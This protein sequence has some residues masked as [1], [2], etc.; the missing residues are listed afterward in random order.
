VVTRWSRVGL[1]RSCSTLSP[2]SRGMGDCLRAR[3]L[4]H[5][6]TSHPG[7]FSLHGNHSIHGTMSTG[8]GYDHRWEGK[9]RVL[10]S[11]SPCDQDCWYNLV[12]Q[13]IKGAGWIKLS[14]PSGWSGPY[15]G[16]IGFNRRRLKWLRGD[17]LQRNGHSVYAKSSPSSMSKSAQRQNS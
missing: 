8:D 13:L 17:E 15:T 4:S 14:R 11:S 9:R 1:D 3:K 2:V 16:L 10:R 5:Y 6:V 12:S 7:Q